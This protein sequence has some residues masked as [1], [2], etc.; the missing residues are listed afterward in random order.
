MTRREHSPGGHISG[1]RTMTSATLRKKQNVP[2]VKPKVRHQGPAPSV[3]P[4][5]PS[6]PPDLGPSSSPTALNPS[7]PRLQP[8]SYQA[9]PLTATTT[10]P[11]SHLHGLCGGPSGRPWAGRP[12]L[13]VLILSLP[14]TLCDLEQVPPR[15]LSRDQCHMMASG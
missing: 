12:E 14:L 1:P 4:P 10:P 13:W 2:R 9:R 3:H 7:A 6:L 5:F 8:G 15:L 11:C